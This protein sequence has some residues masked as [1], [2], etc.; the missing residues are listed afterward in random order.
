M[1]RFHKP[2]RKFKEDK[3]IYGDHIVD[4]IVVHALNEVPYAELYIAKKRK[5]A[6]KN[7]V[8]VYF[9]KDGVHIDV[10]VKIHFTQCVSDM[11][12]KIQE[13]IRHNVESMT[14]YHVAT[15]NVKV[16]GVMFND[17]A[18]LKAIEEVKVNE[19]VGQDKAVKSEEKAKEPK[20]KVKAEEKAELKEENK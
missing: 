5:K 16:K 17:V 10:I 18:S 3:I 14:E 2:Q 9:D 1:A 11:A 6:D 12:F 20:Q 15:I 7:T 4:E 19:E 13:A 8:E